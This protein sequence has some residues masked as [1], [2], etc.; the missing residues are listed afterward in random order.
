[1]LGYFMV[2]LH[3][4][5]GSM[6]H[7][8]YPNDLLTWAMEVIRDVEEAMK[9]VQ[10]YKSVWGKLLGATSS[11]TYQGECRVVARGGSMSNTS[12]A[13]YVKRK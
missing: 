1:M 7:P 11:L 12:Y 6:V 13:K 8:H 5:I 3:H 10:G 2:R 9:Y 4:D